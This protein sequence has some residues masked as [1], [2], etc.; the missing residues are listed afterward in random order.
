MKRSLRYFLL[1]AG[2]AILVIAAP[3]GGVTLAAPEHAAP[4][5]WLSLYS[6]VFN[7]VK[8]N[9]VKPVTDKKLVEG[10]IEGMLSNLD[11]HS[12]YM[13][14]KQF[15]E[16][17]VQTEGEFGGLGMEVT[18]DNGLVKVVSPIDDT[19]AAKAGI[20]PG[21]LIIA[22]NDEPVAEM[23]LTQAVDKLR[24]PI[25][26]NVTLTMRRTGAQPFDLTLT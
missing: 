15:K 25:G 3:A 21:D 12:D 20:L 4:S 8:A 13:D 19:P 24:G 10:G 11:P 2:S 9:Y 23:T 6:E 17:M 7:E 22:I 16:M 14:A 5:K 1:G 18:M 26:S